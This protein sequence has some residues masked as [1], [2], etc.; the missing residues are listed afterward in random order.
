MTPACMEVMY[1]IEEGSIYFVL[2][3]RSPKYENARPS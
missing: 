2:S 3:G 1:S